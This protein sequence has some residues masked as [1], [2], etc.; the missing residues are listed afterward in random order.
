VPDPPSSAVNRGVQVHVCVLNHNS[1]ERPN[2]GTDP[3]GLPDAPGAAHAG[4]SYRYNAHA[5]AK[6]AQRESQPAV[7]VNAQSIDQINVA[8]PQIEVHLVPPNRLLL[9]TKYP[10]L[11]VNEKNII[12]KESLGLL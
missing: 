12:I 11:L 10:S 9:N 6:S 8:N 7:D 3:A 2:F 1:S 5:V 4:Y